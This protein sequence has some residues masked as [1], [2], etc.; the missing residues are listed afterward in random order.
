ML[1]KSI[2][3]KKVKKEEVIKQ[4]LS[5]NPRQIQITFH[6]EAQLAK[7][8][9]LG[10]NIPKKILAHIGTNLNDALFEIEW[11]N[12]KKFKFANSKVGYQ[13]LLRTH[14][15]LLLDY[16]DKYMRLD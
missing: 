5:S 8:G 6:Q 12:E 9:K 3:K 13:S 4:E 11:E 7:E 10:K 14:P 15:N 2:R 16:L 1:Q